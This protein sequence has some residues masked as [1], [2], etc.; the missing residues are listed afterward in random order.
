MLP[1]NLKHIIVVDDLK[2]ERIVSAALTAGQYS[3]A[4]VR[5][6]CSADQVERELR[7]IADPDSVLLLINALVKLKNTDLRHQLL[8][9]RFVRRELRTEWKRL[10][11]VIVYSPLDGDEFL[12]RP[13]H[14]VFTDHHESHAYLNTPTEWRFLNE[15][16][17]A[18]SAVNNY[19][20]E[21]IRKNYGTLSALIDGLMHDLKSKIILGDFVSIVKICQ[22]LSNLIPE[23]FHSDF[24][25]PEVLVECQRI[26]SRIKP[27]VVKI[28]RLTGGYKEQ[29]A[30]LLKDYA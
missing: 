6:I 28:E 13:E 30:R 16:I 8:G 7:N 4:A 21:N 14:R 11:P 1:A 17:S 15:Y 10:E 26:E 5:T 22:R 27:F 23:E 18:V 9:V 25:I 29:A 12:R 19:T 3:H 20:L 24:N 2:T